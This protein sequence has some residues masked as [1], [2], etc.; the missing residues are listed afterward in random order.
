MIH[1]PNC[2]MENREGARFCKGCRSP[3][4]PSYVQE[5]SPSQSPQQ[6]A[7]QPP[8]P[9][10]DSELPPKPKSRRGL[11][12]G[13]IIGVIALCCLAVIVAAAILGLTGAYED[14]LG[15]LPFLSPQAAT[16]KIIPIDAGFVSTVKLN[17]RDT[18]GFLHLAEAYEDAFDEAELADS[19]E[20]MEDTYDI[21]FEDDIQPWLGAEAS[22]AIL[23]LGDATESMLQPG[24]MGDSPGS[25]PLIVFAI[26][27]RDR[28]ASDEFLEKLKAS[29]E[30]QDYNVEEETYKDVPF[31]VQEVEEDW[32]TP[33]I[34]GTVGNFVVITSDVEGMKDV[35][36]THKGEIDSLAKNE[37]YLEAM[38]ELPSDASMYMFVNMQDLAPALEDYADSGD[39]TGSVSSLSNPEAYKAF[40]M[41]ATLDSEGIQI[42]T[43]VTIDPEE[44]SSD[45]LELLTVQNKANPGRILARI[46]DDALVFASSQ[47]LANAWRFTVEANSDLEDQLDEMSGY[48]GV[49]VDSEFF[50][51]T[52]GE[53]ALVITEARND[54]GFFAIFEVSNPDE[55]M[56]ALDELANDLEDE[57]GIE[58]EK[59]TVGGVEMQVLIDPYSEE[60][61]LGY[62]V[63]DNYMIIGYT[64]DALEKGVEGGAAPII[65]DETFKK[66][67]AH[68]PKDNTGYVY[69]NVEKIV[70]EIGAEELELL[71]G[72]IEA[73]VSTQAVADLDKGVIK[74][75]V[76]I[77]I[78]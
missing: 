32:E 16:P 11:I 51:W 23:N 71:L 44:L 60:I 3:L 48:L 30:D 9:V 28:K 12:I 19:L 65:N 24:G 1:C 2:G 21:S 57:G 25:P 66:I 76:Y 43:A 67:V 40:G 10:M 27:T 46:P 53:F 49:D 37:D 50:A 29:I 38:K 68:L 77:Y 7:Y 34:F 75:T 78:P 52:T 14:I 62:G 22:I 69:L 5:V 42:D 54:I 45:D 56:D 73:I 18:E 61:L 74:N 55:A 64:E 72:P 15:L 17:V 20:E 47:D 58:F 39:L 35:I 41:A 4:D 33:V 70:D 6:P 36:D 59:E 63:V 13:I 31:Y 8:P 26:M